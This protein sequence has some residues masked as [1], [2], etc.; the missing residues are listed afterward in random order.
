MISLFPEVEMATIRVTTAMQMQ[1]LEL[2]RQGRS[3]RAIAKIVGRNRR[4]VSRIIKRGT[5]MKPGAIESDWS[6]LIDWEKV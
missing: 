5:A 2:F 3:E 4:T 6:K 1:I